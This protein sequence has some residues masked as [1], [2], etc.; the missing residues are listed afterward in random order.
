MSALLSPGGYLMG[1]G[2]MALAQ[3]DASMRLARACQIKGRPA[4]WVAEHV[5]T[6]RVHH[7]VAMRF[8]RPVLAM[9]A[10]RNPQPMK[11]AA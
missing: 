1:R 8:T 2:A 7:A 11:E 10:A 3:R 6:A 4:E 9:L 5:A